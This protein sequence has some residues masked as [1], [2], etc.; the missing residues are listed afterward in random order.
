MVDTPDLFDGERAVLDQLRLVAVRV[1]VVDDLDDDLFAR[2]AI[3]NLER[4]HATDQGKERGG[5]FPGLLG[6]ISD[7]AFFAPGFFGGLDDRVFKQTV[8][9]VGDAR[10]ASWTGFATA[11]LIKALGVFPVCFSM[12]GTCDLVP[13][14]AVVLDNERYYILDTC[15]ESPQIPRVP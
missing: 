14:I 1:A 8:D 2:V 5:M 13:L 7:H 3:L 6:Q 4:Q 9:P 12:P 11:D 10:L 15:R